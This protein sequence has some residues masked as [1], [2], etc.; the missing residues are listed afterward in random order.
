MCGAL[1]EAM[2]RRIRNTYSETVM[3]DRPGRWPVHIP[4]SPPTRTVS[5]LCGLA[6]M[7]RWDL[8]TKE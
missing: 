5:G 6:V 2:S 8:Q 3:R 4:R 1:S 7:P